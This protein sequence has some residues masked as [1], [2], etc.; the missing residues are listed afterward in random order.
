MSTLPASGESVPP[1]PGEPV[2]VLVPAALAADAGGRR[3]V[4]VDVSADR[5]VATVLDLLALAHPALGRR[6]R[7]EAG[8]LRRHVNVFVG[9][10]EVR[11]LDGLATRVPP[12][13]VLH[14]LPSIAGG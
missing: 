7:D 8:R 12:G 11:T 4:T 5:S 3:R 9:D 14:L 13:A 2:A 1:E 6:L 10:D